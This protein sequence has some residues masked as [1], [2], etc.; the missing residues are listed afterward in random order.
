MV[1]AGS[2]KR[3]PLPV[4]SKPIPRRSARK[5]ASD[6]VLAANRELALHR[7][8]YACQA[9]VMHPNL[10]TDRCT[11]PL[12]VHHRKARS[13]GGGHDLENLIVL[14]DSCHRYCHEHPE[15]ARSVGLIL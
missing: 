11:G 3:S 4:R 10:S 6:R 7:D 15:W 1:E 12:V 13:Q 5:A 8:A 2:V 14:A 9:H